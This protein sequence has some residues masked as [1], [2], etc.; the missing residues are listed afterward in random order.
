MSA[1]AQISSDL[2]LVFSSVVDFSLEYEEHRSSERDNEADRT[3]WHDLVRSFSKV[4]TFRV[5]NGLVS[6]LS[7]FLGVGDGE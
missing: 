4:E 5:A 6:D 1:A 3:R 7:Q 2:S